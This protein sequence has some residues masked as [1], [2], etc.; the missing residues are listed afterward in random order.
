MPVVLASACYLPASG[1][2]SGE[3]TAPIERCQALVGDR[4][5]ASDVSASAL[6]LAEPFCELTTATA[7]VSLQTEA[8]APRPVTD[9]CVDVCRRL[10]D[11]VREGVKP[12][13]IVVCQ[14]SIDSDYMANAS[15]VLRLQ[16]EY[17]LATNAFSIGSLDGAAFFTALSIARDMMAADPGIGNFLICCAEAWGVDEAPALGDVMP[18]GEG[19]SAVLLTRSGEGWRLRA[20]ETQSLRGFPDP[21]ESVPDGHTIVEYGRHQAAVINRL[22]HA[23]GLQAGDIDF[24]AAP[25]FNAEVA[26]SVSERCGFAPSQIVAPSHSTE[27]YLCAADPA[28]RLHAAISRQRGNFGELLLIWGVSMA[29]AFGAALFEYAA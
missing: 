11:Q 15:S 8:L 1:A 21:L 28:F 22:L 19:A 23:E 26:V 14:T 17:G 2:G 24:V 13:A 4:V 7:P 18:L 3:G 5:I 12:D 9:L 10:F 25:L 16:C 20:V 27:G 29:G 6:V